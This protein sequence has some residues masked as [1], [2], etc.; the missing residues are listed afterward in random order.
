[1]A[2]PVQT[3]KSHVANSIKNLHKRALIKVSE[4]IDWHMN[5]STDLSKKITEFLDQRKKE[6]ETAQA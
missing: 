6:F 1:M 3:G 2:G 4:I 5:N